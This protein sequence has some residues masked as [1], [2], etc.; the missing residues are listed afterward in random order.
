[1]SF[2]LYTPSSSILP[3]A[4]LLLRILP[5]SRPLLTPNDLTVF[6]VLYHFSV[7]PI[8]RLVDSSEARLP[9][10]PLLLSFSRHAFL[11]ISS[12]SLY[13]LF[14]RVFFRKKPPATLS[15]CSNPTSGALESERDSIEQETTTFGGLSALSLYI[16]GG[17][18]G[19]GALE[20]LEAVKRESQTDQS[21]LAEGRSRS[22]SARTDRPRSMSDGNT[23]ERSRG[24][25][26]VSGLDSRRFAGHRG[27]PRG[28]SL[29]REGE[30]G[31]RTPPSAPLVSMSSPTSIYRHKRHR[32]DDFLSR[33]FKSMPFLLRRDEMTYPARGEGCSEGRRSSS[34]GC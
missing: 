29:E 6:L 19:D 7:T 18:P 33:Q 20:L 12:P 16:N 27:R 10:C 22:G 32:Q 9:H 11:R 5:C 23:R 28:G 8:A 17:C 3:T 14:S 1:M 31:R 13:T 15:R 2:S 24:Q 4:P 34:T 26:V 21:V 30:T 25:S